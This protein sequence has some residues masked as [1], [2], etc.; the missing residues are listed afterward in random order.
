MFI[1]R[2]KNGSIHTGKQKYQCVSCNKQ[3]VEN[4]QNKIIL[5][6]TKEPIRRSLLEADKPEIIKQRITIQL[7]VM[8]FLCS[9]ENSTLKLLPGLI[10]IVNSETCIIYDKLNVAEF[11]KEASIEIRIEDVKANRK[12]SLVLFG[13]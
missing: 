2:K 1:Y 6:G 7:S 3:F 8:H 4:P 5:E 11:N 12:R 13:K 9:A 10:F